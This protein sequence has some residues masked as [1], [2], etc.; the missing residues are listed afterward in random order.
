MFQKLHDIYLKLWQ[1]D[2]T[3]LDHKLQ[4]EYKSLLIAPKALN[5]ENINNWKSKMTH[6]IKYVD[7]LEK[8]SR[9][10][11]EEDED[12]NQSHPYSTS[13]SKLRT[14]PS[15]SKMIH[16][17]FSPVKTIQNALSYFRSPSKTKQEKEEEKEE[18]KEK[19]KEEEKKRRRRRRRI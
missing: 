16:S 10:I 11:E 3:D 9:F 17:S 6:F 2:Q 14:S 7:K 5:V 15:S 8:I 4:Q 1:I 19:E 13:S 12:I 18:E